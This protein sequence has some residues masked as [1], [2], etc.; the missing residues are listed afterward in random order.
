[1]IAVIKGDIIASR[2]VNHPDKWLRPLKKLFTGWGNTPVDWELVWGDF[3]QLEIKN[4]EEGLQKAFVIK[5]LIKS[6]GSDVSGKKIGPL[7]VRMSIG[8]GEK[9]FAGSRVSESNGSA[10]IY[11]GEAF[12]RLKKEKSNLLIQSPWPEF[13]R[14]MNLYLRLSGI[15]MDNW[16]LSSAELM[17]LVL[18]N[19]DAKQEAF[20]QQLGIRQNSVSGRWNRAKGAEI[21]EVDSVFKS[22]L[23]SLY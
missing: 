18:N 21:L 16:S 1:M 8:I 4:P 22:K 17:S 5:S 11:S 15:I 12:D 9:S 10:Y 19:P 6:I 20:G 2:K 23:K 14:E 7:D 13:D 3:F